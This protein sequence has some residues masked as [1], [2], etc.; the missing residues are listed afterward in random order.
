[1]GQC[2][3]GSAHRIAARNRSQSG[4]TTRTSGCHQYRPP[5]AWNPV[6]TVSKSRSRSRSLPKYGCRLLHRTCK[7]RVAH[8]SSRLGHR[9]CITRRGRG[10][11]KCAISVQDSRTRTT[12]T[13]SQLHPWFSRCVV[14]SASTVDFLGA[15]GTD[16]RAERRIFGYKSS[17]AN[18]T[19]HGTQFIFGE[20]TRCA[21]RS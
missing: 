9:R 3:Q 8:H 4:T 2:R 1:M 10:T 7:C 14:I 6:T 13:H 18:R 19:P 15:E 11:R 12:P 5:E 17:R 21:H 20:D 16:I